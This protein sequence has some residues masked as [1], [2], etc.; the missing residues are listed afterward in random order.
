MQQDTHPR[1]ELLIS[2]DA[3][4]RRVREM[5][6]QISADYAGESLTLIGALKGCYVL[7]ADLSR[8]ID[9]P[10]YIDFLEVSSY[11][12][13]TESSGIVK[14]TKD[15]KHSITDQHVLLIEDIVDT[16][17]TLNYLMDLLATRRPASLAIAALLVKPEKQQLKHPLK[18]AGF[19]IED[20]FV[21]GYGMDYQGY[22]RNLDYV[23]VIDPE[24]LDNP[25]GF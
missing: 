2:A 11:G 10:L 20:R 14:I 15:F 1:P 18:Y 21:V 12:D 5:G 23:G 6:A 16:G 19:E 4:E 24:T 25:G 13:S 9:L 7:M 17:L 22:Y 8:R 3:I